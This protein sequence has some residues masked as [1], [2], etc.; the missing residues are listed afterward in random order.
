MKLMF[1]LYFQ[2][3]KNVKK[4]YVLKDCTEAIVYIWTVAPY[5]IILKIY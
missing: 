1:L 5:F 2:S 4:K 3:F